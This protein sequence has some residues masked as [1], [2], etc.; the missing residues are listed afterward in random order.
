M[1]DDSGTA[2]T[3]GAS[4]G[5]V[6]AMAAACGVAVADIY[7]AQPLL[8]EMQR[9]FAATAD[10]I[11]LIPTL[12]QAGFAAG[13]LL[14]VPLGDRVERRGLFV[15]LALASAFACAAVALAPNLALLCAASLGLGLV[16]VIPPAMTPYAATV[17]APSERGRVVGTVMTGLLLGVLLSRTVGGLVG[18][19]FGWRAVF[20]MASAC[21]AL[22]A[23]AMRALLPPQSV[24]TELGYLALLRSLVQLTREERALRV[25]AVV[26]AAGFAAFSVFWSTLALHLARPPLRAGAAVAGAFGLAGAAG[27]LAAPIAG[28]LADR[29]SARLT[30]L[31]SLGIGIAGFAACAFWPASYLGL[32]IGAFVLDLGVQASHVTNLSRVYALRADA[33]S[34]LNTVYMFSY[35]LGGAAGSAVGSAAF[36][37]WGWPGVCGAGA[38]F[39]AL[40]IVAQLRGGASADVRPA[41]IEVHG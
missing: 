35:F 40:A 39:C 18:A 22:L 8:G 27:A 20:W 1:P 23:L 37:R 12:T 26:G 13:L 19:R 16:A 31:V 9:S 24:R 28:R 4:R 15:V 32:A 41:A 14:I 21:M 25:S 36:G 34:R 29:G 6:L 2:P 11:G 3:T 10:A 5:L 17:A 30:Q 7:Y 38:G 33:R